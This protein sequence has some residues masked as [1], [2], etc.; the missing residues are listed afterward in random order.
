MARLG[1]AEEFDSAPCPRPNVP[2]TVVHAVRAMVSP[3]AAQQDIFGSVEVAVSLDAESRIVATRIRNSASALLNA[4]ALAAARASSFQ[5]AIKNCRAVA[6]EFTYRV[7]FPEKVRYGVLP[8]GMRTISI[9]ADATVTRAPDVAIIEAGIDTHD[10][11]RAHAWS[12][13][14]AAF[15]ALKAKLR[16]LGVTE[17]NMRGSR[18]TRPAGREYTAERVAVITVPAVANASKAA[19]A[20]AAVPSV[21]VLGIR[22]VLHDHAAA[23][24]E[25]RELAL[26]DAE[27][28]AQRQLPPQMLNLGPIL[29]LDE[30]PNAAAADPTEYVPLH[31]ALIGARTSSQ[32]PPMLQVRAAATVAYTLLKA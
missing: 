20:A 1:S 30:P 32:A 12:K 14:D 8:S 17:L 25:A 22:Y 9:A 5:T 10:P 6:S 28:A 7:D 31:R 11:I 16:A 26:K 21:D 18:W 23:Y 15:A 29:R 27:L 19:L 2:A 13:N 4:D 3:M 24:R